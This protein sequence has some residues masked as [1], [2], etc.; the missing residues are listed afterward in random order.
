MKSQEQVQMQQQHQAYG[1]QNMY[2]PQQ[3]GYGS[4]PPPQQGYYGSY[5]PPPPPNYGGNYYPQSPQYAPPPMQNQPPMYNPQNP[6][7]QAQQPYGNFGGNQPAYQNYNN[8]NPYLSST[9][10]NMSYSYTQGAQNKY[11]SYK[12]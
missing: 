5:N 2:P 9:T 4:Y 12:Y 3:Y 6:Q 7:I 10:N 1:Q 11:N 8:P